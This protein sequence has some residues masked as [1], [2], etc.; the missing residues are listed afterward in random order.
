MIWKLKYSILRLL[1]WCITKT[2]DGNKV[3]SKPRKLKPHGSL[4]QYPHQMEVVCAV[5]N[6]TV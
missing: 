2:H 6:S 1:Q 3:K 4:G 5:F